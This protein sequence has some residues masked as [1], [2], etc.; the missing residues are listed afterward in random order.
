MWGYVD[1]GVNVKAGTDPSDK[2][3]TGLWAGSG[4]TIRYRLPLQPG[5]YVL[6][7]GFNEWWGQSRPM[8]ESVTV[9]DQTVT[10]SPV[11][12]SGSSSRVTGTVEFTVTEPTTVTY[13][14]A[15]N[16]SQDP[17]ISWIAVAQQ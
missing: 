14:V 7:A 1:D 17:V 11:N 16:G 6:S 3:S 4:K 9:G 15:K 8:T 5:D 13:T 12:L 2:Y 10:G